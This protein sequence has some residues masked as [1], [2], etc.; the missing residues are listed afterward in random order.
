M[1]IVCSEY[2]KLYFMLIDILLTKFWQYFQ[3]SYKFGDY[4]KIALH[5][6][7][8]KKNKQVLYNYINKSNLLNTV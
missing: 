7:E 2:Y 6:C 5:Q 3:G 1:N 4:S 8:I